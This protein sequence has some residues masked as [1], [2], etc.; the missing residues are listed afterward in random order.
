MEQVIL[1]DENDNM[2][3]VCEKMSAHEQALLHRA[4]SVFIFNDNGEMLLQKRALTKYHSA[5]LWTNTCC[6]HPRPGEETMQAAKRRLQEEMG[7]TCPIKKAFHFVYRS[8]FENGLA[9]HEY[10]HVFI[11]TYQGT[12][13][14]NP[15]EVMEYA[16]LPLQVIKEK[17][18]SHPQLFTVWFH[19]A[20]P[21]VADWVNSKKMAH[22]EKEIAS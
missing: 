11:G 21:K 10:D 17:L 15:A 9:E 7:F 16:Y 3:G 6:S 4:F 22:Q 19:I 18:I 5:G 13:S 1:I 14:I 8:D 2:I 20:F 12:F